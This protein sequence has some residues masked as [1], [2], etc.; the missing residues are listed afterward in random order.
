MGEP[1]LFDYAENYPHAPGA[2]NTATS[3]DAARIMKPRDKPLREKVLAVLKAHPAGLTADEVAEILGETVLAIRPRVSQ[4]NKLGLVTDTGLT[5]KN[6][7]G[8][9]ASVWSCP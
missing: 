4:L 7:S 6:V 9:A 1:N 3:R 2:Q 8:V 5:R